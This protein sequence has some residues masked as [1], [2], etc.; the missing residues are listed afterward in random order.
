VSGLGIGLS[1]V[2]KTYEYTNL[3]DI[4]LSTNSTLSFG[5]FNFNSAISFLFLFKFIF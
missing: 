3:V 1:G 2:P 5:I 4:E